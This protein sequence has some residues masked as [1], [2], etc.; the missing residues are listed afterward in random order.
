MA[1]AARHKSLE[2][3]VYHLTSRIAACCVVEAMSRRN[4]M[5]T[6]GSLNVTR[7]TGPRGTNQ[8]GI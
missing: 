5:R 2:A 4:S 7:M 1:Q 3:V 6:H 8:H